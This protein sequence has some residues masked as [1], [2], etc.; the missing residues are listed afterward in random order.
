MENIIQLENTNKIKDLVKDI[1]INKEIDP[2]LYKNRQAFEEVI[3]NVVDKGGDYIIK[4]LPINDGVKDILIDVKK[5]FKTKDFKEIIKTAVNSSIREGLEML[6]IPKNVIKDITKIKDIALKGG[7]R[8]ALSAGID[9]VIDKYFKNN[10]FSN[11]IG[12]FVKKT[13]DFLFSNSFKEKITAGMDKILNK[14]KEFE[15]LCKNWNDSYEKFDL[16]AINEIAKQIEK[17]GKEVK[18]DIE[19]IKDNKIIQNMTKLINVK[20]EKL[21]QIQLQICNDL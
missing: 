18:F 4:A 15:N 20:K 13:K 11:V 12:E 8:Q 14:K 1:D 5:A 3:G 9:I 2:Q 17:K 10:L 21:S 7:L 6:S 16:D 19:S